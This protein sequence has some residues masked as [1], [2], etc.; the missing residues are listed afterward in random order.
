MSNSKKL[1]AS[2][3]AGLFSLGALVAAP[4]LAGDHDKAACK[5]TSGCKGGGKLEKANCKTADG[6]EK[7]ACKGMNSCKGNGG[8]GKNACK[9]HGSCA[10]D[11]S[12]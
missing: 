1:A 3:L 4:A 7:H 11:G 10:T 9:G 2:A 12:K 8:D 6:K 5:G